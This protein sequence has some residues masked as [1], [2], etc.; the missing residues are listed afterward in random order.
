MRYALYFCTYSKITIDLYFSS[1]LPRLGY[2]FFSPSISAVVVLNIMAS[3]T[4]QSAD[5]PIVKA[6]AKI[7]A[8]VIVQVRF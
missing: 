8:R 5:T 4:E 7:N 3:S 2:I 1:F 6:M